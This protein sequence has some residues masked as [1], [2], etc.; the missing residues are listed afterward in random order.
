MT[1]FSAATA[2]EPEGS[3]RY[4][5]DLDPAWTIGGKPNGG[6]LLAIMA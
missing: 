5:A 3:N 6:Y 2:L 4:R 1:T